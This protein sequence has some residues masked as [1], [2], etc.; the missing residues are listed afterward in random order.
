MK[1]KTIVLMVVLGIIGLGLEAG[2]AFSIAGTLSFRSSSRTA[3]GRVVDMEE[4]LGSKGSLLYKPVVEWEGPDGT[5]RRFTGTVASSPP[6]YA[7]G[8]TVSV[9]YDP[10]HPGTVQF[11]SFMEN[12]FVAIMLG[13]FGTIVTGVGA[14]IA[15]YGWRKN[16]RIMW[17]RAHGTRVQAKS[18]GV[19][20]DRNFSSNG[21][22]PWRLTAQWQNPAD[23][24]V[25]TFRSESIWF[26]PTEF[27]KGETLDVLID[28]DRP[29][30]Y[31]IDLAF[32]PPH[33]E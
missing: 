32:L 2:A 11:D 10:A 3:E 1:R 9:R 15:I 24:A 30:V 13:V 27:V 29:S 16:N 7:V 4:S 33:A 6:S 21:R 17:L 20:M 5:K 22:H 8:D 23:N 25:Y 14:G 28:K 31:F 19:V 26:D 18:T 12:W